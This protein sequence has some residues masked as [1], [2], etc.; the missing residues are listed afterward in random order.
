M[1]HF[2]WNRRD[3]AKC[4]SFPTREYRQ[5]VWPDPI[6][7]YVLCFMSTTFKLP[8]WN[9]IQLSIAPFRGKQFRHNFSPGLAMFPFRKWQ[10][11][12][13]WYYFSRPW[14]RG[15]K[16]TANISCIVKCIR[17]IIWADAPFGFRHVVPSADSL[18]GVYR[19]SKAGSRL[20]VDVA[21][22][23][24]SPGRMLLLNT[25]SDTSVLTIHMGS[26][27]LYFRPLH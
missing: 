17:G 9:I 1:G 19:R 25:S 21:G 2:F 23:A 10:N 12:F 8:T 7:T 13:E 3:P 27:I 26:A 24:G 18:A 5:K 6:P 14:S 22:G 11:D 16:K 4:W 15:N 20:R